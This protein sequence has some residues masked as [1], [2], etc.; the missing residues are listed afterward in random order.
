MPAICIA[1]DTSCALENSL[2]FRPEGATLAQRYIQMEEVR[3][4]WGRKE[5]KDQI[6]LPDTL[7]IHGFNYINLLPTSYLVTVFEYNYPYRYLMMSHIL[8]I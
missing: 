1:Q 3:E 6:Q 5:G 8:P 7:K 2:L 4:S